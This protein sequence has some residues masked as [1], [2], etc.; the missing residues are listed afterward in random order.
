MK[1]T[2]ILI[3]IIVGVFIFFWIFMGTYLPAVLKSGEEARAVTCR[4]NLQEIARQKEYWA[5]KTNQYEGA[6][7]WEDLDIKPNCPKGGTYT[8]GPYLE[9]PTCSTGDNGTPKETFDDHIYI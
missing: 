7:T 5:Y 6:P 4:A 2:L 9:N 1:K 3:A 8:I